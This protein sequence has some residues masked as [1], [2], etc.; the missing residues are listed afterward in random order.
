MEEWFD[1]PKSYFIEVTLRDFSIGFPTG[2]RLEFV[3]HEEGSG[4][5]AAEGY[6]VVPAEVVAEVVDGEDSEDGEGDD[7]LDDLELVG[8]EG[9]GTDAVSRD[10]EAV[11]EEG[12]G[13][14]DDDDLPEGN[15]AIFEMTVPSEGHEDV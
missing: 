14:T 11:L 4:D 12:D 5:E 3:E 8:G 9:A 1:Q 2:A 13:P 10:L 7:L 6:G 15:F